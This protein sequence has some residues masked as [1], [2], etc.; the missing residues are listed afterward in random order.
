MAK[1]KSIPHR[2]STTRSKAVSKSDDLLNDLRKLIGGVRGTIA[3]SVNSALLQ[4]YW[5]I[6]Q[7]IR[8]DILQNQR[9]EYGAEILSTLSTKLAN[10]TEPICPGW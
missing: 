2:V 8:S 3:Q 4:L 1:E 10:T 9:A 7:R 5:H 6:G